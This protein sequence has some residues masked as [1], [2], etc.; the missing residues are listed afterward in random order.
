[1]EDGLLARDHIYIYRQLNVAF[2]G[3]NMRQRQGSDLLGVGE[4]GAGL[5]QIVGSLGLHRSRPSLRNSCMKPVR[6]R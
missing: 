5:R 4:R 3:C 2:T 6:S 1:M